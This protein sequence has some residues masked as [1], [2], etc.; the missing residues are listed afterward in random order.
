MFKSTTNEIAVRFKGVKK[1]HAN[2][3]FNGTNI[4]LFTSIF[5][6][7]FLIC[8]VFFTVQTSML[9]SKVDKLIATDRRY[10]ASLHEVK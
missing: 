10:T 4:I 3:K 6:L 1:L 8:F 9:N 2:C 7:F 5:A